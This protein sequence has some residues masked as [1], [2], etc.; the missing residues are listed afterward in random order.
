MDGSRPDSAGNTCVI[1][2]QKILQ[3]VEQ[4]KPH[5]ATIEAYTFYSPRAITT[6]PLCWSSHP[7]AH[8]P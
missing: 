4:L 6:E 8:T 2:S 5:T 3:A 7:G 1:S